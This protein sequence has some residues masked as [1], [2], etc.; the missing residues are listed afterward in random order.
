MHRNV[1]L[2]ENLGI[3]SATK[4][5]PDYAISYNNAF[6]ADPVTPVLK[7]E[8]SVDVTDPYYEY[9]KYAATINGGNPVLA[10]ELEHLKNLNMTLVGN[11]FAEATILKDLKFRSAGVLTWHTGMNRIIRHSFIFL[12]QFRIR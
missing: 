4:W 2:G 1:I 5:G 10:G 3:T 11:M 12:Q 8:G 9:E 7:P 6:A